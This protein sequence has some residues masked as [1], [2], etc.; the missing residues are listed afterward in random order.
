MLPAPPHPLFVAIKRGCV[1]RLIQINSQGITSSQRDVCYIADA[2]LADRGIC[3][4]YQW[5]G[6]IESPAVP[7]QY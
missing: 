2:M 4:V 6:F 3:P 5:I 1:N 7:K